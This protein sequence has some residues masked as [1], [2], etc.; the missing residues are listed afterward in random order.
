MGDVLAL[1]GGYGAELGVSLFQLVALL[2]FLGAAAYLVWQTG[3]VYALCGAVLLS[4]FSGHWSHLGIPGWAGPDRLLLVAGIGAV[5][6]GATGGREREPLRIGVAH[7]LLF[8]AAAYAIVSAAFA[9]TL[10][11]HGP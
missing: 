3:P 10:T 11:Q 4:P 8:L 5:L 7:V 1:L 2:V 6:L 9:G